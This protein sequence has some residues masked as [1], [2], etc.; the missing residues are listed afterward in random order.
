MHLVSLTSSTPFPKTTNIFNKPG[1]GYSIS[2]PWNRVDFVT[3]NSGQ[4]L[5]GVGLQLNYHVVGSNYLSDNPPGMSPRRSSTSGIL[6]GSTL[7][8]IYA[9]TDIEVPLLL[10]LLGQ[11]FAFLMSAVSRL[12]SPK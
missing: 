8:K 3:Q 6:A 4:V 5:F 11:V 2:N 9:F 1:T 7:I 10:Y 12:D